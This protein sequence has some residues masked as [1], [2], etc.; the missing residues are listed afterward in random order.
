MVDSSADREPLEELA[1]EFVQ[2]YRAGL[3]PSLSSFTERHPELADRIR[4]LFPRLVQME[5]VA[6]RS[7]PPA[8]SATG[9]CDLDTRLGDFRIL[10]EV[11]RGGMGIVYEAEQQSLGRRVALKVLMG[12]ALAQGKRRLRF[13][14]EAEAA[15]RLHHTNIVPVYGVGQHEETSFYVMQ[16]IDGQGLNTVLHEIRSLRGSGLRGS[17]TSLA[18]QAASE[19]SVVTP[20]ARTLLSGFPRGAPTTEVLSGGP[21]KT[22]AATRSDIRAGSSASN[23]AYWQ[24]VARVGIQVA[25]ALQYAHGQ[26]I[27]HRDIKPAN[28][29]L[30]SRGTVWVTDFGL[31]KVAR[32]DDLTQDGDVIGTLRYMAPEQFAS[33]S[34]ARSDIYSLGLTLYELLTLQPAF[35]ESCVGAARQDPVSPRKIDPSIPRDLETIVLKACAHEPRRRYQSADELAEDLRRFATD[36]PIHAR[37]VSVIEHGWRWCRRN[38]AIAVLATAVALSMTV[39]AVTSVTLAFRFQAETQLA[40]ENTRLAEENAVRALEVAFAGARSGRTGHHPGR[41]LDTLESVAEATKLLPAA[42]L[43]PVQK[44]AALRELRDEAIAALTL[45][46]AERENGWAYPADPIG[47]IRAGFDS[48][49]RQYARQEE[50]GTIVVRRLADNSEVRRLGA[51]D[52]AEELR[53]YVLFSP[54]DQRLAA[55]GPVNG[56]LRV[57]VWNLADGTPL[58]DAV[59]AGKTYHT[60]MDFSHDG[61]LLAFYAPKRRI[62]LV[63]LETARTT[64]QLATERAPYFVRFDPTGQR[65]A[66]GSGGGDV[67]LV[68]PESPGHTTRLPH[69]DF[70]ADADWSPDGRW[71][72][73]PCYDYHIRVW[74][75]DTGQVHAVCEGHR[76]K[77]RHVAFHPDRDL[78]MS[79]AWDSSTRIWNLHT[80]Q[81]LLR[82]TDR[83]VRFSADGEWLGS[84]DPASVGVRRWQIATA[85]ACRTLYGHDR[86]AYVTSLSFSPDGRVLASGSDRDGVRLWDIA[87]ARELTQLVSEPVADVSFTGTSALLTSNRTGLRRWPIA[88]SGGTGSREYRCGP[89]GILEPENPRRLAAAGDSLLVASIGSRA[90]LY[91]ADQ[92][93]S[94]GPLRGPRSGNTRFVAMTPDAKWAATS[95]KRAPGIAIWDLR[96]QE[97]V[98]ELPIGPARLAFSPDGRQLVSSVFQEYIFWEVG[99]WRELSRL[100]HD[101]PGY[102]CVA[103]SPDMQLMAAT[104][105][106]R[107]ILRDP[108]SHVEIATLTAPDP[109][110]LSTAHPEGTAVLRFSPDGSLLA[111]GAQ[112]GKIRLWAVHGIRRD[113]AS[114]GLDWREDP[115]PPGMETALSRVTLKIV[116]SQSD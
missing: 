88:E 111:V 15:A 71:L 104:A 108:A 66:I 13:Q 95:G 100:K 70:V 59:A 62:N 18:P 79:T 37:H 96:T 94:I 67:L 93:R 78:L 45:I 26:G 29:L 28:L 38:P 46:D 16:F 68:N 85:D 34:D 65:L 51:F 56:K 64:K 110:L 69:P 86:D 115:L 14:R 97:V 61:R 58:L 63:D 35:D 47:L 89:P 53:V 48:A 8:D 114:I 80:G 19:P 73:T 107:V 102:G 6:P 83:G 21:D 105:S 9:E 55:R 1:E 39:A 101:G 7:E 99:T 11:A 57:R 10:R 40:N 92:V 3:R 20:V 54:D 31:A 109:E 113:L 98:H 23:H 50:D 43:E 12:G 49:V 25:E 52:V 77:P 75:T 27:H 24:S 4:R 103:F 22:L 81:E 33:Q 60:N 2:Q 74:N 32:D 91:Q 30:D 82:C 5:Q 41:R 36:R 90:T 76:G 87:A 106:H 112:G 44:Q 17:E 42:P 72:A 116:P 84:E